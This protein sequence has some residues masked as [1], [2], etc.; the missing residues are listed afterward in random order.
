M[1]RALLVDDQADARARLR[2]LLLA[3][4]WTVEE[5]AHGAEALLKARQAPPDLVL[6]ELLLPVLDGFTLLRHW[7]DDPRC[8]LY[9]S[10][11]PRD[12]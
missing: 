6:A 11:S 8:L 12:S 1:T 7:R 5:A 3:H 4:G 2:D 10:P 9:T